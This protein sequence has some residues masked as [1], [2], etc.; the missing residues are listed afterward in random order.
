MCSKEVVGM[1]RCLWPTR[2]IAYCNKSD[3]ASRIREGKAQQARAQLPSLPPPV[4]SVISTPG[5]VG[6]EHS[7]LSSAH[8]C[9]RSV[10]GVQRSCGSCT[11]PAV[12]MGNT[13]CCWLSQCF[14]SANYL[15]LVMTNK[16][17][18]RTVLEGVY[19]KIHWLGTK[20]GTALAAAVWITVILSKKFSIFR[21][22]W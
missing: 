4:C 22:P 6:W 11:D 12:S 10:P 13:S 14:R 2:R 3:S 15:F 8:P 21:E 19:L 5:A 20:A 18:W 16:S 9:A 7:Q 17:K 1:C